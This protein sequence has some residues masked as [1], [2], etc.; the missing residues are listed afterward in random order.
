MTT[1]RLGLGVDSAGNDSDAHDAEGRSVRKLGRLCWLPG[2][3]AGPGEGVGRWRIARSVLESAFSQGALQALFDPV[4]FC[5]PPPA[6]RV[7]AVE[8]DLPPV[9]QEV[10]PGRV[11]A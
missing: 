8:M 2:H 6:E 5:S 3:T 10:E 7:Q 11:G 1:P 9:Q 4:R